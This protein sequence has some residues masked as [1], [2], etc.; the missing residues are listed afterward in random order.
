MYIYEFK[1]RDTLINILFG[2]VMVAQIVTYQALSDSSSQIQQETGSTVATQQQQQQQSQFHRTMSCYVC[3]TMDYENPADNLCRV[4]RPHHH[5]SSSNMYQQTSSSHHYHQTH[6]MTATTTTTIHPYSP[7]TSSLAYTQTPAALPLISGSSPLDVESSLD[8]VPSTT[9]ITPSY[10]VSD[11][12]THFDDTQYANT[13]TASYQQQQ[14]GSMTPV[15]HHGQHHHLT[16]HRLPPPNNFIR[17]RPCFEDENFCSIVSVVRI[18]F[19]NDNLF[20]RFWAMERNCSKSCNTGCMLIGERVRLRVCSQCCRTP[21]C[22]IGS[23]TA[24]RSIYYVPKFNS[25]VII[26]LAL[27]MITINSK[28]SLVLLTSLQ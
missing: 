1:M 10:N 9:T 20:S 19:A 14:A 8:S 22:N 7:E 6:Q 11:A 16:Q 26:T 24:S 18:E 28:V 15:A 13:T 23:G 21:N 27:L 3:S 17:T 5:R 4:M 2:T 12:S 25:L